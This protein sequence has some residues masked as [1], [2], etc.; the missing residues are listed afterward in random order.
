MQEDL[1]EKLP[2]SCSGVKMSKDEFQEEHLEKMSRE[3]LLKICQE[4]RIVVH[5]NSRKELLIDSILE[6]QEEVGGS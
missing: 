3:E 2:N 5:K 6:S 1:A 4:R